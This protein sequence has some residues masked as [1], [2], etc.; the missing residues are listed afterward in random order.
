MCCLFI[1][2]KHPCL[3]GNNS[4]VS[5][6]KHRLGEAASVA[7]NEDILD[8][9]NTLY[10]ADISDYQKALLG[11]RALTAV[12]G[13]TETAKAVTSGA[14]E[15]A[16]A[17]KTAVKNIDDVLEGFLKKEVPDAKAPSPTIQEHYAHHNDV[18]TE[19]I[20]QLQKQGYRVS[21]GE[22]SF[23]SSWSLSTELCNLLSSQHTQRMRSS[24]NI[25]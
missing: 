19:V 25:T 9:L 23:G 12:A 16:K 17:V 6:K 5:P 20:D 2:V 22:A 11:A 21:D 1:T 3:I 8:Q 18:R 10:G 7:F 14:A 15:T 4:P 13:A 24:P